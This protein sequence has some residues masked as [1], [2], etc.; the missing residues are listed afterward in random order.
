[1]YDTLHLDYYPRIYLCLLFVARLSLSVSQLYRPPGLTSLHLTR[2]TSAHA[3]AH[4]HEGRERI[5]VPEGEVRHIG[6][7]L[8]FPIKFLPGRFTYYSYYCI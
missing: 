7:A 3:H 4:A 8:F 1:M 2:H 6:I 5:R